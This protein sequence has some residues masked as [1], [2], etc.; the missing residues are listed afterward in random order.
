[1]SDLLQFVQ[2]KDL[3]NWSVKQYLSSLIYSKYEITSL[4]KHIKV[5]IAKIKLKD[6]QKVFVKILT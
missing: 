4:G 6:F 1:M 2:F 5:E 3:V